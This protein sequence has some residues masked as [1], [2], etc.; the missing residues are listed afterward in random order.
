MRSARVR[1]AVDSTATP[2]LRTGALHHP[3]A[4][5]R[6]PRTLRVGALIPNPP[7]G[8]ADGKQVRLD[9][10]LDGATAML[11]G[12]EPE[13]QLVDLC[14]RHG[15]A[16]V[17]LTR[18]HAQPTGGGWVEAHLDPGRTTG[19]QALVDNPS[20]TV[21]VRP[22]RAIATVATRSRPPRL[23]WVTS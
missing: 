16:L 19:L 2:P 6:P 22:D 1:E 8:L 9:E 11:T 20:L 14:G 12:R 18:G 13:P 10:I 4:W 15:I 23:P 17:R 7:L 3:P 5:S 21:L